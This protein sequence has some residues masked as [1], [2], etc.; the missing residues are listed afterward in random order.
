M[1]VTVRLAEEADREWVLG[2]LVESWFGPLVERTGELVNAGALPALIADIDGERVGVAT[3]LWHDDHLE[4]V[5]IDA[6]RPFQGI[7]SALLEAAA[8]EAR[9]QGRSEIR[10]FATNDNLD[11]LRFYQRRGFRL[12]KVYRDAITNIRPRKPTIPLIGHYEI[13]MRDEIELRWDVSKA[14]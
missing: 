3:L 13:P 14:G 1:A 4:I 10:L 7:G 2:V 11:A 8:E 6:L 12:W 5:T 9:R